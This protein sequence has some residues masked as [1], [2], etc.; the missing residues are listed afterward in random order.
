M[1]A[2]SNPSDCMGSS[3]IWN[4]HLEVEDTRNP[5]LDAL[6]SQKQSPVFGEGKQSPQ[7]RCVAQQWSHRAE[8]LESSRVARVGR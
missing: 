6:N 4:S 3:W 7:H 5:E 2:F 1:D 8:L